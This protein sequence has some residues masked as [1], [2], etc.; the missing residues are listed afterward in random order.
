AQWVDKMHWLTLEQ[1]FVEKRVYQRIE[2][3]K[4]IES[5]RSEVMKGMARYK[6]QF[7]RP[8]VDE[9]VTRLLE[10]RIRRISAYDIDK[11]RKDIEEIKQ[12]IKAIDGKLR[13]M[14]KTTIAFVKALAKKYGDRFPRRTEITRI[15]AIDKKSVARQNIKLSFDSDSG[16][17]GSDV[18]GDS[19]KM[20]V[21][22][23]DLVLAIAADGSYRVMAAPEKVLF[24]GKLIYCEIFD[25]DVGVEFTVVYRDKKKIAYGKRIRI[26][27]FIRSREYQLIKD[28]GGKVDLL[29][30][31]GETGKVDLTFVPAKRQRVKSADYD[32][33]TLQT[34]SPTARGAR[35]AAKAVSRV[36]FT[37]VVP[38]TKP[39]RKKAAARRARGPSGDDG[40]GQLL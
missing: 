7:V 3:A 32:L 18:R 6:K 12:S 25:P 28:K 2:K 38:P 37:P 19:H 4:T 30:P 26:E 5:V 17:F 31:A 20:T 1:I 35:L 21:T 36:K 24:G 8:M 13:N 40:Q 9:D 15:K 16:F 10:I 22:E 29:L 23:Y 33:S 11:N 34:T 27:R 14:K 39:A